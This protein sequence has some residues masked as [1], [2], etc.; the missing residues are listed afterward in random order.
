M[1]L[2]TTALLCLS[3]NIYFEARSEK[4]DGQIAVAEVTLN[5]V[6]SEDYTLK[7]ANLVGGAMENQM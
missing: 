4:V 7:V 1:I 3:T 6:R 2:E 5:R